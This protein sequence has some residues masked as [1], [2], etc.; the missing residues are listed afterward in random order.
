MPSRRTFRQFQITL[1]DWRLW[2]YAALCIAAGA[3][4]QQRAADNFAGRPH[5]FLPIEPRHS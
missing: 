2:D 4:C 3:A 1:S 5:A